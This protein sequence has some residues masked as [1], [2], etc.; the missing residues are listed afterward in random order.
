MKVLARLMQQLATKRRSAS[1]LDSYIA[2]NLG[3]LSFTT[4]VFQQGNWRLARPVL[5]V[6]AGALSE[7]VDALAEI[8]R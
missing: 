5:L 1:E 3:F 6:S 4:E 7:K 2:S 8:P